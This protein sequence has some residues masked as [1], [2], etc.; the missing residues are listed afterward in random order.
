MQLA[1]PTEFAYRHLQGHASSH[2]VVTCVR[3]PLA[4]IGGPDGQIAHRG[5][6][7]VHWRDRRSLCELVVAVGGRPPEPVGWQLVGVSSAHFVGA[8]MGLVTELADPT[9]LIERT[10]EA[11]ADGLTESITVHNLSRRRVDT[12]LTVVRGVRLRLAGEHQR[13]R[14]GTAARTGNDRRRWGTVERGRA[15]PPGRRPGSTRTMSP[16]ITRPEAGRRCV[17]RCRCRRARAPRCG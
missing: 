12:E 2:E 16:S 14:P 4:A 7:G 3:A 17:G 13:R 15:R 11:R 8:A 10:R 5:A 9:V 1:K 6:E